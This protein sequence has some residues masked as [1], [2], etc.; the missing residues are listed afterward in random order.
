MK[1]DW[2]KLMDKYAGHPSAF[3]ADVDCTSAGKSLCDEI[4]VRGYP[5]IKY[6]N[7]AEALSDYKGGRDFSSLDNFADKLKPPCG[8]KT[9]HLCD[10]ETKRK[11]S[12][13]QNMAPEDLDALIKEKEDQIAAAD[14]TYKE[15][16]DKLQNRYKELQAEKETTVE[17]VKNSGLALLKQVKGIL[18]P[19]KMSMF[20]KAYYTVAS[21][22][23]NVLS[24]MGMLN[25]VSS[26]GKSVKQLV[27]A[28]K[29]GISQA[30]GVEL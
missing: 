3:V 1:P 21:P 30:F 10:E 26:L 11:I 8:L 23:E 13:W 18:Y 15:A 5:T 19:Y 28:G 16:I 2:D 17:A 4:G 25:T 9:L 6:G 29:S 12:E 7:P 22:V 27:S 24:Q 14:A 20:E